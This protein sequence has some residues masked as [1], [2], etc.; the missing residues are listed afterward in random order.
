MLLLDIKIYRLSKS[1]SVHLQR[2]EVFKAIGSV[3]A[4]HFK[5]AF[6]DVDYCLRLLDACYRIAYD[7]H[8]VLYH[9]ESKSRG[10]HLSDS[11]LARQ[12]VE[13]ALLRT[14]WSRMSD[15]DLYYNPNFE[16][17]ARPFDR[18]RAPS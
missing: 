9:F 8:A 14:R 2:R 1:S 16:R 18:L 10:C 3:D 17:H 5:V 7:P 12:R 4:I 11:K 6:N 15:N 13:A